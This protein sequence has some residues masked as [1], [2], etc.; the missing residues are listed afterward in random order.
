MSAPVPWVPVS[1]LM[2]ARE[3]RIVRAGERLIA[4]CACGGVIAAL[5]SQEDIRDAVER[6]NRTGRHYEWRVAREA[7]A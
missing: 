1:A 5:T 7:T 6:H 3:G 2:E 4:H